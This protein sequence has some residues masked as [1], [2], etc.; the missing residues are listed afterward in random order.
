MEWESY[1]SIN[2]TFGMKAEKKKEKK[3]LGFGLRGVPKDH[4]RLA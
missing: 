3:K 1:A 2:Y 4:P